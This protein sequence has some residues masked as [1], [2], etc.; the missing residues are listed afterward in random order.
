[1]GLNSQIELKQLFFKERAGICLLL[2]LLKQTIVPIYR[3]QTATVKGFRRDKTA[4][5]ASGGS[6]FRLFSE[7]RGDSITIYNFSSGHS[8]Y[9][10]RARGG[11]CLL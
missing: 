10:A 4:H 3:A 2:V 7:N 1:V 11:M 5:L 8:L 9:S 6:S